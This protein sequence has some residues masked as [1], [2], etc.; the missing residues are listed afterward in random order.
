MSIRPFF[1]DNNMPESGLSCALQTILSSFLSIRHFS[2]AIHPPFCPLDRGSW[3][4]FV[5]FPSLGLVVLAVIDLD[6]GA[7]LDVGLC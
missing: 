2:Q 6:V 5:D 7:I 1:G 3:F 4:L